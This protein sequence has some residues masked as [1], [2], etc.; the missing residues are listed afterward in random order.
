MSCAVRWRYV[1][2]MA[3]DPRITCL[4]RSERA[5]WRLLA[6]LA[7]DDGVIRKHLSTR[8]IA[9]RVEYQPDTVRKA[10]YVLEEKRLCRITPGIGRTRSL[11]AVPAVLGARIADP[12]PPPEPVPSSVS[13]GTSAGATGA[14]PRTPASSAP[15]QP[16]SG[17]QDQIPG[18]PRQSGLNDANDAESRR[19]NALLQ[20]RGASDDVP[21]ELW[22]EA[23]R[24]I[25]KPHKNRRCCQTTERDRQRREAVAAA[26]ARRRADAER[27]AERRQAA[28]EAAEGK[29]QRISRGVAAARAEL[30]ARKQD[31]KSEVN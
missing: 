5:V 30:A 15:A 31:P 12:E 2:E 6:Q 23:A 24:L 13:A 17:T 21:R 19:D 14:P 8:Y 29:V 26:V 11:Y 7:D 28:A 20:N 22:C 18:I 25:G 27:A 3:A 4:R 9:R 16:G 10:V 1:E